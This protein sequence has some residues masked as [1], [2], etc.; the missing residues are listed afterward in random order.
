[1]RR[2]RPEPA[3]RRHRIL[4]GGAG[5]LVTECDDLVVRRDEPTREALVDVAGA[6][7]EDGL[8]QPGL[9]ARQSERDRLEHLERLLGETGG[10]S[11][12]GVPHGR[13]H[14][15]LAGGEHLGDEERVPARPR[16]QVR[17]V[18]LVSDRE[19]TDGGGRERFQRERSTS[20]RGARSP[21][22]TRIG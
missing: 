20:G 14:S 15:R 10:A 9:G 18:D 22:S 7:V 1:M 6:V 13:G 4:D 5:D 21:S 11:E 2:C 17:G 16:V 19:L 12:D 8:E 3:C